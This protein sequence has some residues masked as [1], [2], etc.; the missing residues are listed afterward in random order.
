MD[1]ILTRRP[2]P[3][4]EKDEP[5]EVYIGDRKTVP[6]A[7]YIQEHPHPTYIE[8]EA[9]L[10]D[11]AAGTRGERAGDI[12]LLAH[13]GDRDIPDERYYFADL[14]RSWHGSPSRQDSEVPF[15]VASPRVSAEHIRARVSAVLGAHPRQQKVADV[16]LDLRADKAQVR[17]GPAPAPD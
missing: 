11:L 17:G 16:L 1:L 8:L 10:N 15:I 2:K 4:A 14:Y 9:R 3:F 5:F 6:V 13:N 12:M 7:T